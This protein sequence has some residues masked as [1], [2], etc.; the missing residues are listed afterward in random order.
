MTHEGYVAVPG[1]RVWYCRS[2]DAP[3]IP[4]LTLHGGPG[5][6]SEYL[7]ALVALADE[8]PVI[9]YDQLGSGKSDRPDDPALWVLDRFVEELRQ[10]R[11]QLGLGQMHL[12]GHSWGSMLATEYALTAPAG[13][14]SLIL[15]GPVLSM[16]RYAEDAHRLKRQLPAD[17][18]DAIERHEAA[19]TTD[20]PEYQAA[21]TEWLRRHVCRAPSALEEL[22]K[23]FSDPVTGLNAQ[24]YNTMQGPSEF[25][26]TGNLKDWDRTARVSEIKVPTLFTGGRFDECTPEAMDWYRSLIPGS[27]MTIFEEGSHMTMLEEPER[28]VRVVRDFLHMTDQHVLP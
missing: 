23:M 18:Q 17:W 6:T 8:R 16:R 1:G 19:G 2:G 13:L 4:L 25:A 20:A 28:Y 22:I 7:R 3:G 9:L 5:G 26:I 15:S 10:V 14:L 27:K 24:I 11:A 12:L 21:S